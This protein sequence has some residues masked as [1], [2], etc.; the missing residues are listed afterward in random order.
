MVRQQWRCQECFD[1]VGEVK[2]RYWEGIIFGKLYRSYR[3]EFDTCV[4]F[5]ISLEYGLFA[6]WC[7]WDE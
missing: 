5:A 1:S 2:Q 4:L 7:W 6:M 3:K